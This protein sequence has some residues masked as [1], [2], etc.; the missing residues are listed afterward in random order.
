MLLLESATSAL[1]ST[2]AAIILSVVIAIVIFALTVT[3]EIR[4]RGARV[5][6]S[7]FFFFF[8]FSLMIDY[9]RTHFPTFFK[10]NRKKIEAEVGRAR[11]FSLTRIH[12][13]A[14]VFLLTL[15]S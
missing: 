3:S 8:F 14:L 12:F 15:A 6:R 4:P 9:L 13:C 5:D 10:A 11:A 7:F 2:P 1:Y